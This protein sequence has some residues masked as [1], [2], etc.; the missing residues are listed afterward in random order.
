MSFFI[1][2]PLVVDL[3]ESGGDATQFNRITTRRE[4]NGGEFTACSSSVA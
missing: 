3:P 1:V 4:I 2:P